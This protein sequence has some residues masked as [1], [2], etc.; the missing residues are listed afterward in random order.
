MTHVHGVDHQGKPKTQLLNEWCSRVKAT[1]EVAWEEAKVLKEG[2]AAPVPSWVCTLSISGSNLSIPLCSFLSK[3]QPKKAAA[4]LQCCEMAWECLEAQGFINEKTLKPVKKEL[5][6]SSRYFS[7]LP[8]QKTPSSTLTFMDISVG[9]GSQAR[10]VIEPCRPFPISSPC[11]DPQPLSPIKGLIRLPCSLTPSSE[12]VTEAAIDHLPLTN[13]PAFCLAQDINNG[14]LFLSA[15]PVKF[16]EGCVEGPFVVLGMIIKGFGIILEA[17]AMLMANDIPTT[18]L[19]DWGSLVAGFDV[20]SIPPLTECGFILWPEDGD[21]SG[22]LTE[23]QMRLRTAHEIRTAANEKHK[24][25]NFVVSSRLYTLALRFLDRFSLREETDFVEEK[26]M[27]DEASICLVNRSASYINL[28]AFKE[29][30]Y[31]AR[32]V[33]I[34]EPQNV[35]A[36]YKL[37]EAMSGLGSHESALESFKEAVRIKPLDPVLRG[38]VASV[39][40]AISREKEKHAAALAKFWAKGESVVEKAREDLSHDSDDDFGGLSENAQLAL[41]A[42]GSL[43]LDGHPAYYI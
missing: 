3:P 22:G 31:D 21:R 1:K 27:G 35:K 24:G 14:S 20:S 29:A 17:E 26:Q 13:L 7:D 19:T 39:R 4:E 16:L 12:A 10:L 42:F 37:G 23:A 43:K 33:L 32:L 18:L 9:G 2:Q 28:K 8:Q 11:A 25:G 30:A 6:T 40:A 34:R 41:D 15:R 38:K 5:A 36:L